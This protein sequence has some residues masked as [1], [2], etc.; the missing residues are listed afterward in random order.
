MNREI[1][2]NSFAHIA[3]TPGGMEILRAL[4]LDLAVGGR[5]TSQRTDDQSVADLL[6]R[7]SD[8][9][10][11]MVEAKKIRRSRAL[12]GIPTADRPHLPNG[13][14]CVR[15]GE[16]FSRMGAGST[17]AGGEKSYVKDGILFLR[18]QNVFNSGLVLD[19][20][21]RIPE[22]THE[23]MSATKVMGGDILL[24]ITGASIGRVA[25]VP[26][27]GWITANVNQHGG[28]PGS[29]RT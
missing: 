24:N 17:P 19:G 29:R 18:S 20:A 25:V 14:D 8:E 2:L 22:A 13:W 26:R 16:L 9:R 23:K 21:A 10:A 7:L 6:K 28:C 12:P 27:D 5:L 4:I 15:F 11:R 3:D 1:F